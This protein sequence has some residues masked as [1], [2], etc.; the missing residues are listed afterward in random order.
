[1]VKIINQQLQ[2]KIQFC[3]FHYRNKTKNFYKMKNE[4]TQKTNHF[5][6][7]YNIVIPSCQNEMKIYKIEQFTLFSQLLHN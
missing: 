5:D 3:Y 6:Y 4:K 7:T 1:M 2:D